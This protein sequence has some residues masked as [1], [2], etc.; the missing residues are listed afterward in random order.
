M[1]LFR[2][3]RQDTHLAA[4][5]LFASIFITLA[6]CGGGGGS[7]S[8]T[9]PAPTLQSV[10]VSPTNPSTAAG[11]TQ[12]FSA[13][14]MY[15]DGSHKDVTSQVTWSSSS[16]AVATISS[17]GLATAVA[18]GTTTISAAMQSMTGSTQLTVTAATLSKIEVTPTNPSVAAGSTVQLTA[19]G[20]YSDNSK[21]DLTAQVTWSSSATGTATVSAAGL[22]T[23]VAA[24]MATITAKLNTVSGTD[25]ITVT[26]VS[27]KS[28][29]VTPTSQSVPSNFPVQY[30]ATGIYSDNSHQDITTQ[31]TWSSSQTS[32]ATIAATTGLATTV[33]AGVTTISASLNGVASGNNSG[34][35]TVSSASLTSITITP[36]SP[37]VAIG[38]T[39]QLVATGN[40]SDG[41]H[42]IYTTLVTWSSDTKSVATVSNASGSNGLVTPV[43]T[44]KANIT[45][46][47]GSVTS[48]PDQVT[49]TP[50]VVVS[51]AVTPAGANIAVNTTQQYKAVGTYS[52]TTTQ[53]LTTQ[54]TWASTNAPAATISNAGGSQGLATGVAN[55]STSITATFSGV[56]GSTP[57]TVGNVTLSSIAIL[58]SNA[59]ILAD[60]TE[61]FVAL[62]TYNDGSSQDLT[63]TVTW[64][65][66]A[67][68]TATISNASGSQ[69]L[70]TAVGAVGSPSTTI[71][72]MFGAVSGNATLSVKNEFAYAANNSDNNVSQFAIGDNTVPAN[73]GALV[74]NA[75]TPTVATGK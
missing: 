18:A 37:S 66:S 31:V 61:Q 69:G 41:S 12:Q 44:G 27:L 59:T 3:C 32:V 23:G 30:T 1:S 38:T 52:D 65:S 22:V 7:G 57:L 56:T 55:G 2:I 19:M 71:G 34:T 17:A 45:A 68:T 54:V 29:E 48:A 14:G 63:T 47:L 70:A 13:T 51:I 15:S 43:A 6:S 62:G 40:L 42:P 75:T 5:A 28:I 35:L 36:A 67:T 64:S 73:F 10:D 16:T 33:A 49:V 58:P 11:D 39:Q 46:T 9:P 50:A 26:G 74:A 21:K 20:V 60:G 4:R 24:G 8:S 72:A 25:T 53:D